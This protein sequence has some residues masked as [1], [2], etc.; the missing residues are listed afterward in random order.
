MHI[1][2]QIVD[3]GVLDMTLPEEQGGS[4]TDF[5]SFIIALEEF[6]YGN[7]GLANMIAQTELIVHL[8]SRYGSETLQDIYIS[9]KFYYSLI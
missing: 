6:A 8:L 1:Y 2:R 7:A 4:G 3:L 5:L 9:R